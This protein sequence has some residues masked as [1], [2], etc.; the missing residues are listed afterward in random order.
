M[1]AAL[2]VSV[3]IISYNASATMERTLRSACLLSDD[4]TVVDSGSTDDTVAIAGK[5]GAR[6][7]QMEWKGFGANKNA[8]NAVA[9]YDWILSMDS[10]EVLSGVAIESIRM[11]GLTDVNAVYKIQRINYLSGQRIYFGE[12]RNDWT[13]RLF[14]RQVVQWDDALV[15][16]QLLLPSSVKVHKIRG[17]LHHYTAPDIQAYNQKLDGYAALVAAKYFAKAEKGAGLKLYF[18][19]AF[20]F[21]KFYIL[22]GGWMDKKAGWQIAIAHARYSF[23]KYKKL[24]ALHRSHK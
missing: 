19:P 23:K 8:G 11:L 2:P 24:H 5:W 15:H 4:I 12:W 10:D 1:S 21:L 9:K 7:V 3:V 14:N 17:R 18:S 16:E 20:S 13:I 22:L 6:V